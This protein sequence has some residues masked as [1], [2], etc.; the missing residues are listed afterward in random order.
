MQ[1]SKLEQRDLALVRTEQ[2]VARFAGHVAIHPS[3]CFT[4]SVYVSGVL[5]RL[6]RICVLEDVSQEIVNIYGEEQ[7]G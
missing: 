5:P 2:L 4:K 7:I 6:L 1:N 3:S